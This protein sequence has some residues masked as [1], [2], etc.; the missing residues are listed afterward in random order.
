MDVY[1]TRDELTRAVGAVQGV[2]DRRSTNHILGH[3]LL[4]ASEDGL[5]VTATDTEIT[6]VSNHSARV[7]APGSTTVNAAH[8]H[9]VARALPDGTVRLQLE[10]GQRLRVEAGPALFRLVG[11]DAADFPSV[12]DFEPSTQLTVS[13]PELRRLIDQTLF[14]IPVDDNRYGLNG[15]HLENLENEEGQTLLRLVTTDG[16]RLCFA[17]TVYEGDFG[18][19]SHMLIPRKALGEIRRLLDR[20]DGG[21]TIEFGERAARIQLESATLHARLV[22]GEFPAYR[23]VLPP[24]YQRLVSVRRDDFATALKRVSVEAQDRS[25]IMRMEVGAEGMVL[26]SRT[27]D[28]GEAQHPVEAELEGEPITIGFNV[29]FFQDVVNCIESDVVRL[30]MGTGLA[31]CVVKAQESDNVL[32]VVMPMRL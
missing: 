3:M 21:A 16:S 14:A 26:S 13:S 7:E 29:R 4:E 25:G 2:A 30:E 15:G 28:Q 31:P 32:F 18:M 5:R 23:S 20:V 9:Q 1:I 22:D 24:S 19:Q 27:V 17:Q 10:E 8:F 12:P 11:S 6:L